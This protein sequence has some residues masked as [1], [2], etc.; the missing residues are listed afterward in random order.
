MTNA[1]GAI[2][3][4][5]GDERQFQGVRQRSHLPKDPSQVRQEAG[6]QA[7]NRGRIKQPQESS[8]EK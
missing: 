7:E 4:T 3:Y 5:D 1:F 8:S 6:E 2:R